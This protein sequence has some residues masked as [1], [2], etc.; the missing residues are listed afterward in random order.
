MKKFI[1]LLLLV[2]TLSV[3]GQNYKTHKVLKGETIE[4]IAK[5][6]LVTPFDIYALNPDLKARLR[7]NSVLIIPNSKVKNEPQKEETQELVGYKN[8][9]VK[10]KETLFSLS[11]KYD[12]SIEELKKANRF[13]Y[14]E[15]LKKGDKLRIP[16]FKTVI[17]KKSFSNTIKKY[18]VK[19][20]EGKWRIAYK[21]GITVDE[22]EDLNP[23][24]KDVLQPGDELNVPNIPDNEEKPVEEDYNYYEVL[25][26]EG[27]YRLRIKTGLLQEDLE[28][29][30]P[31]LKES[32]LKAG[33]VLKLPAQPDAHTELSR[34][35]LTS[36]HSNLT[37]FKTKKIALM[38]PYRLNRVDVDS[39]TETK[40][41][42]KNSRLLSLVLDFHAGALLALD[43]AKQLGISTDLKVFDTQFQISKTRD[44]LEGNSFEDY[45]AVI[46]P[47]KSECFDRVATTLRR[48]GVPVV[49]AMN[50]PE[51]VYSNVFQSIPEDELLRKAMINYVK[52]DSLKQKVVVISD[53]SRTATSEMLGGEFP[54]AKLIYS[55]K[56]IKTGKD[57]FFIDPT[58]LEEVFPKGRTIVF[59]ETENNAF[60]SS[61]ISL[62]NGLTNEE[63]QIV[64]VTLDKNRAFEGKNI[65][66]YH[67]S[68]LN[69]HYPSVNKNFE[70]QSNS[71]FVKNYKRTYGVSP[72]KY[73][74]RGFDVTFDLL[75]RLASA[76]D[77]YEGSTDDIETE[78]IENKFRYSKA[79]FGG[80]VNEAL[81]VVKYQNLTI[82]KAE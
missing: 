69:F 42:I 54:G 13:L 28:A 52:A 10:R 18:V 29:L 24:M 37:N 14:S 61:I 49:A 1:S 81:Y 66:N 43:S 12:V 68:N 53:L 74:S 16:K 34:V 11:Q 62:L 23:N 26:K 60:A 46:G 64:L 80:Y 56:N 73:A 5:Q 4:S 57:G 55:R 30:N 40:E 48:D 20:K 50:K 82:V 45:D 75:L 35:E 79:K 32:G 67:L 9:K 70:D 7:P 27:F 25:P 31:V 71:S 47:M 41:M 65:D 22:L 2:F 19:P 76:E 33:M 17:Y 8:H 77:L 15:N 63:E 44:I 38:L 59:L 21:F 6:Y 72:S 58:D 3:F 51:E 39:I 78:Y 36:L